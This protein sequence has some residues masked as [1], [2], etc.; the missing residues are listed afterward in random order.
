MSKVKI[1]ATV[2]EGL[3]RLIKALNCKIACCCES[4][5]SQEPPPPSPDHSVTEEDWN[6][7]VFG[8]D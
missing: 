3:V 5:C 7:E 8:K 6:N 4:Q 2:F 1:I